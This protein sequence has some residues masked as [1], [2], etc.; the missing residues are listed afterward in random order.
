MGSQKAKVWLI[1]PRMRHPGTPCLR[2]P[3][4]E[5]IPGV[6]HYE[7]FQGSR[8]GPSVH[9]QGAWLS[10][11]QPL[12]GASGKE[13]EGAPEVGRRLPDSEVNSG[14][15]RTEGFVGEA[16]VNFPGKEN[17]ETCE[18]RPSPWGCEC[19]SELLKSRFIRGRRC[20]L[21]LPWFL[22]RRKQRVQRREAKAMRKCGCCGARGHGA[23]G[24]RAGG[25]GVEG[26]GSPCPC[27]TCR[28]LLGDNWFLAKSRLQRQ[29]WR[30]WAAALWGC[31][32]LGSPS[33]ISAS[34]GKWGMSFKTMQKPR[35]SGENRGPRELQQEGGVLGPCAPASVPGFKEQ[36]R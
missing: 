27:Y 16:Q 36:A 1:F 7:C 34:S 19:H 10:M 33:W 13:V 31:S 4:R 30:A 11:Y 2:P 18:P 12:V 9:T 28:G 15:H 29:G 5:N 17:G 6:L 22:A 23:G 8:V 25:S 35:S 3:Q 14:T 26:G 24:D 20:P 21:P 32:K